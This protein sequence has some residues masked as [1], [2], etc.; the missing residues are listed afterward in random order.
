MIKRDILCEHDY[1]HIPIIPDGKRND[2]QIWAGGELVRSFCLALTDQGGEYFFL[3]VSQH[4][5]KVLTFLV[6]DPEDI[7]EA[8]L[9]RIVSGEAADSK[10]PFYHGLYEEPLRP[11]FHFS[12]QRGWLNDP[13][14]LVYTD[15]LYHMYYQH[16]PLG[17]PHGGVNICWGHAVSKDLLHWEEKDDAILP[18]RRDW[19]IASGSAVID[20]ENR[21]GYGKDAIIAAFTALGTPNIKKGSG[22]PSGGQFLAASTDGGYTYYLFSHEATVPTLNG[23]G[24]RDPR[25]FRYED[26]YVMAVYETDANNKNCVSFYVSDNFHEWKLASRNEN[27]YECPDIFPLPVEDTDETKWVLYGADGIARIGDFDGYHFIESGQSNPLDYG[28]ATYA[29]QTWSHDPNGKRIHISWVRGMGGTGEDL[30][31]E[32]MPF[33]Q[34]MTIPSEITLKKYRDGIRV[35]R[36]P[37]PQIRQLCKELLAEKVFDQTAE[38]AIEINTPAQYVFDISPSK[39]VLSIRVGSHTINYRTAERRLSFENDHSA[40]LNNEILHFTVLIDTTTIELCFDDSITASYA[41]SPE[42]MSLI[43]KGGCSVSYKCYRMENIWAD[44]INK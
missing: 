9:N 14:G 3:N 20:I 19:S 30:G 42:F 28:N 1:L 4:R 17:T 5:N 12:S 40:L 25:L 34:C 6:A 22:Y 29:G 41:M 10:H 21:A 8:A 39:D 36:A 23:Q 24:F 33:S 31:Y 15:G 27:L 35:C 32:N 13:N 11:L 18:W 16:N 38:T 7:T 44:F 2:I 43:I 37:I 26:H